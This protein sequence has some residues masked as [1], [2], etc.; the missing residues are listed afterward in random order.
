MAKQETV[1]GSR[2]SIGVFKTVKNRTTVGGVAKPYDYT[3]TSIDTTGYSKG[4]P[5]YK[6]KTETGESDKLGLNKVASKT[7]KTISRKEVPSV[8]KSLATGR[9]MPLPSSDGIVNTITNKISELFK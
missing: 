6:L 8:L 9:D 7:T 1:S 5:S 4:K 2:K 3:T